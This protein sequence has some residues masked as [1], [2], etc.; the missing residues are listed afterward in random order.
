M[1]EFTTIVTLAILFLIFFRPGKTPPLENP[2]VIER[3][4]QYHM[5]L[6]PQ[7]NL[8]Q[9]FIEEVA[10]RLGS[11]ALPDCDTVFFEV[12]DRQ[13][14]AHGY[15]FY[16]LAVSMRSGMLLFQAAR[17]VSKDVNPLQVIRE[18]SQGVLARFPG[19]GAFPPCE[20]IAPTVQQAAEARGIMIRQ[21]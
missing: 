13:V 16:L 12:R 5:T 21:L 10:S 19:G 2:L 9:P 20:E 17:P 8:A 3:P 4:G 11:A 15:D 7:L 1:I 6:A 14:T 18:F